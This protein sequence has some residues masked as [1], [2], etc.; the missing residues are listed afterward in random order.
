MA[1]SLARSAWGVPVHC[2][3]ISAVNPYPA[4]CVEYAWV[5]RAWPG[6]EGR[7][8]PVWLSS[9][10]NLSGD[11]V[12]S[13]GPCCQLWR[14]RGAGRIA[15][16]RAPGRA[17]VARGRRKPRLAVAS[18][19]PRGWLSRLRARQCRF[20]RTAPSLV[21]RR[22]RDGWSSRRSAAFRLAT[23]PRRRTVGSDRC[24]NRHRRHDFAGFA[25]NPSA[26]RNA[27][28]H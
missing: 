15:A 21:A 27:D 10:W 28:A 14:D 7:G 24:L 11:P 16:S 3:R 9:S 8:N 1:G 20:H 5:V 26:F 13:A 2:S 17:R 23:R 18:R 25:L 6:D 12:D 4:R 22:C 19:R